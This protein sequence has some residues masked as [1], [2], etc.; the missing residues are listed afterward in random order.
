MIQ[1]NSNKLDYINR[2][3]SELINL[4]DTITLKKTTQNDVFQKSNRSIDNKLYNE[5]FINDLEIESLKEFTVDLLDEG[6]KISVRVKTIDNYFGI[7]ESNYVEIIKFINQILKDKEI[8][9]FLSYEF[10]EKILINWLF[11]TYQKLIVQIDFGVFLI[12]KANDSIKNYNI[13]FPVNFLEVIGSYT[14]GKCD[15][16]FF[17]KESVEEL[18]KRY[19]SA[20]PDKDTENYQTF[21]NKYIGQVFVSTTI[22]AEENRAIDLAYTESSYSINAL[23]ICT[24][25]T[26]EPNYKLN[27]NISKTRNKSEAC[28]ILIQDINDEF[29]FILHRK[30]GFN[31]YELNGETWEY[32]K[33]LRLDI[34]HNF[35]LEITEQNSELKN[36]ILNCINLY[37]DS[38]SN[39]NLN[40]RI[41]QLFTILESLLLKNDSDPI[42]DS[43]TK[44]CSKLI[45]KSTDERKDII[46]LLKKMY[47]VRSSFIHHGINREFEIEDL[48]KLQIY[49]VALIQ[50]LINLTPRYNTKESILLE[51]DE[52]ILNA[53]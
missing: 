41:V 49:V 32:A 11:D 1:I 13:L 42:M 25:S 38:I 27:L 33:G 44:Y 24:Y 14:I 26:K 29:G 37:A 46:A 21:F 39:D 52:A 2:K 23:K 35:L 45:T 31:Y 20:N 16:F 12:K 15:I 40:Q 17:S 8:S 7:N 22:T 50:E 34:F 48:A 51:I 53:Y 30:G 28:E 6:K 5:I 43:V 18:L 10:I 3:A 19:S 47:K 36:L 4:I 9:N